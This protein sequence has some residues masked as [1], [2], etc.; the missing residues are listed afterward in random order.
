MSSP[1]RRVEG[2]SLVTSQ[3]SLNMCIRKTKKPTTRIA[4]VSKLSIILAID[5]YLQQIIRS[6]C[7]QHTNERR[8]LKRAP[9]EKQLM[10]GEMTLRL[11]A[12]NTMILI[13]KRMNM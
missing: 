5:D 2:N 12:I 1:R 11:E 4:F 6:K 10:K 9:W 3:K 7:I 13:N 8:F